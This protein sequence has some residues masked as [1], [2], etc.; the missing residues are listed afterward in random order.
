[1][2]EIAAEGRAVVAT[3]LVNFRNWQETVVCVRSLLAMNRVPDWIVVVENGSGKDDF[4]QL[5]TCIQQ[6][7][8]QNN[9]NIILLNTDAN[10]GFAGG[11]NF[12]IK[13]ILRYQ[14]DFIW[15]LNNDTIVDINCLDYLLEYACKNHHV[16]VTGSALYDLHD[17]EK[18]QALAGH[19]HPWHARPQHIKKPEELHLINY[20]IGASFFISRACYEKCGFLDE[21]YFLYFEETDYCALVQKQGFSLGIS[22]KSK[23]FHADGASFGREVKEYFYTRNLLYYSW[24]WQPRKLLLSMF[25]ILFTR[26]ILRLHRRD[27]PQKSIWIGMRDFF[28]GVRGMGSLTSILAANT[29]LAKLT[30]HG[31]TRTD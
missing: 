29:Q 3:I 15:L 11:C 18:I 24:K 26:I 1:M 28:L 19:I 10:L 5:H 8:S 20:V 4:F 27:I 31:S 14:P 6:E 30:P 7:F 22:L 23:V 12:G 2:A 25:F 16:G 9:A 13:S 17:R 21:S